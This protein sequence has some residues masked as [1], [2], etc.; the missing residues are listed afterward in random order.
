MCTIS[1]NV[2]LSLLKDIERCNWLYEP[3]KKQLQQQQQLGKFDKGRLGY[4]GLGK[5]MLG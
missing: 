1:H 3:K 5:V 2:H 4:V